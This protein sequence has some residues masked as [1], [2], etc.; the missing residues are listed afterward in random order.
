[1][2]FYETCLMRALH[3]EPLMS[4]QIRR[5]YNIAKLIWF[6]SYGE[7]DK[8]SPNGFKGW[9]FLTLVSTL[10]RPFRKVWRY[11]NDAVQE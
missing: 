2:A 9:L 3:N 5:L 6:Y 1:M 10:W 7:D 11:E 8:F 4:S